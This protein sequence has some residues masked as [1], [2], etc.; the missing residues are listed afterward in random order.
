MFI[1][2]HFIP[3]SYKI[4]DAGSGYSGLAFYFLNF[5]S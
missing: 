1:S 5:I 3:V 4:N 2:I